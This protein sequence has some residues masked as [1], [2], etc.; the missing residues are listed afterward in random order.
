MKA[1]TLK[2]D[3]AVEGMNIPNLINKEEEVGEEDE[4]ETGRR[5]R[6]VAN[7]NGEMTK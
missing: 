5:P 3:F 6:K 1:Q 4:K 7:K 2:P